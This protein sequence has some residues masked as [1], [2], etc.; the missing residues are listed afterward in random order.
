MWSCDPDKGVLT[1]QLFEDSDCTE[2]SIYGNV[3]TYK[4]GCTL[5]SWTLTGTP[6]L[7][8]TF[9]NATFHETQ[10]GLRFGDGLRSICEELHIHFRWLLEEVASMPLEIAN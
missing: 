8:K 6:G 7:E 9:P 3:K 2:P 5:S 1:K 10:S 4:F